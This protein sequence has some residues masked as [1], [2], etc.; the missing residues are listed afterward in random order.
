M[1]CA[2]GRSSMIKRSVLVFRE[3][4]FASVGRDDHGAPLENLPCSGAPGR[5]ALQMRCYFLKIDF[6][7]SYFSSSSSASSS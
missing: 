4:N 5:R 1:C 3:I 6:P 2:S 7:A